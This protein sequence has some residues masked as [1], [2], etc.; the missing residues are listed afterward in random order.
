M[1]WHRHGQQTCFQL[2][3][4]CHPALDLPDFVRRQVGLANGAALP[5]CADCGSTRPAVSCSTGHGSI[6]LC[7]ECGAVQRSCACGRPHYLH[8]HEGD[9]WPR[10]WRREH[11]T[12]TGRPNPYWPGDIE[13]RIANLRLWSPPWPRSLG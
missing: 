11:M 9:L 4:L 8:S 1:W 6:D 10:L 13:D 2:D 12:G 5:G 3:P 7:P